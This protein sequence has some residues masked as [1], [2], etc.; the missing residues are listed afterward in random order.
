MAR[1]QI[2][3]RLFMVL[4]ALAGASPWQ[5]RECC[6]HKRSMNSAHLRSKALAPPSPTP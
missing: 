2:A 4:T 5:L 6:M 3:P 1:A